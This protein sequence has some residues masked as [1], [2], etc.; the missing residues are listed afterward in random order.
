[1]PWA[2]W[3]SVEKIYHLIEETKPNI[4]VSLGDLYDQFCYSKFARTHDLMTPKEEISEAREG[5][6]NMWKQIRKLLPKKAQCYQLLGNHDSRI[7][8]RVVER[9]PEILSVLNVQ[10]IY[11]FEGVETYHDA[12]DWLMIEGVVYTHGHLTRLGDHAKLFMKP[13]VHGHTHRG[14]SI[15]FNTLDGPLWELDCGFVADK[16]AV[17]LLYGPTK[18]NLWVK[19]CGLITPHAPMFIP[20]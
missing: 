10:D 12:S 15:F 7:M 13:V 18:H 16:N 3:K 1:M 5:A 2:D 19:G 6:V 14:G 9:F 17:P 11:K 8:K 4:V 20:L